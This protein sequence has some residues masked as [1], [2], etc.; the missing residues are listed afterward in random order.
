MANSV[1]CT[2]KSVQVMGYDDTSMREYQCIILPCLSSSISTPSV[3]YLCSY[4]R[5]NMSKKATNGSSSLRRICWKLSLC[6]MPRSDLPKQ[7]FN[8]RHSNYLR[9]QL[10]L[11]KP[12]ARHEG[13][14]TRSPFSEDYHYLGKPA[15]FSNM[16]AFNSDYIQCWNTPYYLRLCVTRRNE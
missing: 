6:S 13:S 12:A 11:R 2:E 16:R 8:A 4:E 5:T 7:H 15:Y 3:R 10:I 14:C 1:L 9:P